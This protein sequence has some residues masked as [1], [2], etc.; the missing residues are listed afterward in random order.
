MDRRALD[1]DTAAGLERLLLLDPGQRQIGHLH[2]PGGVWAAAR[3][4]LAATSVCIATGFPQRNGP[5]GETDGPPGAA[6]LAAALVQLGKDVRIVAEPDLLP[7]VAACAA[8]LGAPVGVLCPV[9]GGVAD[10]A[11]AAGPSGVPDADCV[12]A[13]E[14]PGRAGDEHYYN[15]RGEAITDLVA[16]AEDLYRDL[17]M[18]GATTVAIGDGGNEIGMGVVAAAVRRH[19]PLGERIGARSSCD[20]LVVAGNANRGA[21]GV[22]AALSLATGRALLHAPATEEALLA[23]AAAA[24]ALDGCTGRCTAAVDGQPAAAQAAW[25][26]D[27]H[28]WLAGL[29]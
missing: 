26:A 9:A 21:Y 16:P 18:R 17:Q 13:I 25:L 8:A 15:L 2:M 12:V 24:G 6:V 1:T 5:C 20:H 27:L 22:V 19:I 10:A 29:R 23:A 3:T 4:L 7:P 28:Q 11:G 14:R